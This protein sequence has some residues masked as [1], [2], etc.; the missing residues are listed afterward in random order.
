MKEGGSM[1]QYRHSDELYHHGVKGMKWGVR[2]NQQNSG[3][4]ATRKA[5]RKAEKAQFK[6]DV[7]E[8]RK[9]GV[10]VTMRQADV[11]KEW[12]GSH[13]LIIDKRKLNGREVSEQYVNRIQKQIEREKLYGLAGTTAA[14]VG[15]SVV[16][17]MLRN[18]S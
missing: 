2:R 1:W 13:G 6:K 10:K 18:R 8:Y 3:E 12:G 5:E 4:R 17:K 9:H 14:L 16:E 7:K 11:E 15:L